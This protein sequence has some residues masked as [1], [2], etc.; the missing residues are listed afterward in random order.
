MRLSSKLICRYANLLPFGSPHELDEL[1]E[2]FIDFQLLSD[3]DIPSTVWEKASIT[4]DDGARAT[5]HR[6]DL[7]WHHL[8]TMKAPDG[9][10]R[11]NRLCQI[12]KLVMVIPHSNAQEERVF[13]MIRKNKTSFRPSLDPKATLSSILTI[14]L[15]STGDSHSYEPS[16][17][18]LRKAKSATWEYNKAH[19][20]K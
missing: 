18:V 2:E 12:A 1:L 19:S 17:E 9:T 15:A 7:I 3:N 10:L 20:K 11:F 6:L 16:Q 8:S 5:Y 13:S 14:K 4:P